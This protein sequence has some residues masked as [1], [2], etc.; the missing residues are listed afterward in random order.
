M[1]QYVIHFNQT[2]LRNFNPVVIHVSN[3]LLKPVKT[4]P[5]YFAKLL[6]N[7]GWEI[8]KFTL[9]CS[10][11]FPNIIK[12]VTLQ[13]KSAQST[14]TN[15]LG[16]FCLL[17]VWFLLFF[18]ILFFISI[19]IVQARITATTFHTKRN[20]FC[21]TDTT[22]LV[23][24]EWKQIPRYHSHYSGFWNRT[25]ENRKLMLHQLWIQICVIINALKYVP[26]GL[27][28]HYLILVPVK[29]WHGSSESWL[30]GL[31]RTDIN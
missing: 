31:A 23:P 3:S 15:I 13:L 29:V 12:S 28:D 10:V 2:C 30:C 8:Y 26:A 1:P 5:A 16:G 6:R 14:A 17:F 20:V 24:C 21:Q 18:F 25:A 27:V 19:C 9:S 11:N 22:I 4:R 7:H